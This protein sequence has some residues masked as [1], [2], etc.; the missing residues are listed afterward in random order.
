MPT[1]TTQSLEK[2]FEFLGR[3]VERTNTFEQYQQLLNALRTRWLNVLVSNQWLVYWYVELQCCALEMETTAAADSATVVTC[4]ESEPTC[5]NHPP[6]SSSDIPGEWRTLYKRAL[7]Y[8]VDIEV[9]PI[10]DPYSTDTKS[11]STESNNLADLPTAL[12]RTKHLRTLGWTFR[13]NGLT[14]RFEIL[15]G[16]TVSSDTPVQ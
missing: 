12:F 8:N 16:P 3:Q 9:V 11:Y 14:L 5:L 2:Y 1:P 6:S 13:Y 4:H 10:P 7:L 15:Q